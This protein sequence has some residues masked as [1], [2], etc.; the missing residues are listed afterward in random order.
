MRTQLPPDVECVTQVY[1]DDAGKWWRYCLTC[2]DGS[3]KYGRHHRGHKTEAD[4]RMSA[5]DHARATARNRVLWSRYVAWRRAVINAETW[6]IF[7]EL[8]HARHSIPIAPETPE[9]VWMMREIQDRM[10]K[11]ADEGKR[12]G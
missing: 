12:A 7:S 5:R 11:E 6:Q 8:W 9:R 2:D 4:A 3:N 1:Q 10:R